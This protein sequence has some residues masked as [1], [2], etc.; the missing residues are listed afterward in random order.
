[1][2]LASTT[3]E[4]PTTVIIGVA[5]YLIGLWVT[6]FF[7]GLNKFFGGLI[8][9]AI[10]ALLWPLFWCC[11]AIV[12]LGDWCE[13]VSQ[14]NEHDTARRCLVFV[15]KFLDFA[16]LPLSPFSFGRKVSDWRNR[17]DGHNG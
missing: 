13:E 17:K 2:I 11:A 7:L 9:I 8:F 1:M 3:V 6:L 15:K 4:I 5:I 10:T 12:I 16:T 14:R